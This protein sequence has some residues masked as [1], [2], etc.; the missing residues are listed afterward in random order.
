MMH[1]Q[2]VL[3]I[4]VQSNIGWASVKSLAKRGF[5]VI[6]VSMHPMGVGLYSKYLAKGYVLPLDKD[7]V[8]GFIDCVCDIVDREG[9]TGV[10]THHELHM[11]VLNSQR[12]RLEKRAR[13]FF[14]PN[15]V[16]EK[17]LNKE[18][19]YEAAGSLGIR[20]PHTVRVRSFD[21]VQ[22][23]GESFSFP[24]VLK[25]ANNLQKH[26]L[27]KK[28]SF[29]TKYLASKEDWE[30]FTADFPEDA[31][32]EFLA[33]EF[34]HGHYVGL[35]L[36]MQDM[37]PVAAF[38][39]R[40]LR[41]YEPGLGAWRVSE[42]VNPKLLEQAVA[43]CR[44]LRYEGVCEVEFRGPSSSG[45]IT[46]MEI[47]PRLW[48][49]VSLPIK[50]GVDFP[51]LVYQIH[52]GQAADQFDVYKTGLYSRNTLGDMKWLYRIV[53]GKGIGEENPNFQV[54]RGRALKMYLGS[55]FR[56][57]VHDLEDRDDWKPA[58]KHYCKKAGLH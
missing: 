31:G 49:G 47:N 9:A 25:I 55:L 7:D 14:P 16:L 56:A 22:A 2:T 41:E 6:G 23:V 57:S 40:A 13:L 42:P 27:P 50:C 46:F 8:S 44:K 48:G 45:E 29:K 20:V 51:W 1:S 33:Q 19:C 21:A 10:L 32:Q 58:W 4:G 43:V 39:W 37:E 15:G 53:S 35:G 38:Q 36:A 28:W 30:T 12:S 5:R 18:E 11:V 3:V 54:S 17:I 34:I 26:R 24:V 52:S